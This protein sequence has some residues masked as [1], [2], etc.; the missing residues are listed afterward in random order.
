MSKC[1]IMTRGRT[2]LLALCVLALVTLVTGCGEDGSSDKT[3]PGGSA[4]DTAAGVPWDTEELVLKPPVRDETP[5]TGPS[6]LPWEKEGDVADTIKDS[7]K[8]RKNWYEYEIR[9]RT[10]ADT[11][12]FADFRYAVFLEDELLID[13]LTPDK[14]A[15][16][17]PGI[18]QALESK[19]QEFLQEE[20][21]R[22]EDLARAQREKPVIFKSAE[23]S[24]VTNDQARAI[25][26]LF[27]LFGVDDIVL[28]MREREIEGIKRVYYDVLLDDERVAEN[29][30]AE[31]FE[32]NGLW[33][34]RLAEKLDR[35]PPTAAPG[36]AYL[37]AFSNH[38]YYHKLAIEKRGDE[39][40]L[41]EEDRNLKL[42][43]P[44]K[45]IEQVPVRLQGF[46]KRYLKKIEWEEAEIRYAKARSFYVQIEWS[47][48][49]RISVPRYN[50]YVDDKLVLKNVSR[51]ELLDQPPTLKKNIE[52]QLKVLESPSPPGVE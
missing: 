32:P 49:G 21:K 29:V 2:S 46:L 36:A 35:K 22:Q 11:T 31:K 52:E 30:P 10:D 43:L 26:E 8:F 28:E 38:V 34:M 51:E 23:I 27:L 41:T 3:H 50:V 12:A 20:R 4:S 44:V 14:F 1:N 42:T 40:I 15:E 24:T 19:F 9:V 47:R 18:R 37:A 33:A 16:Q 45:S 13:N 17:E 5:D 48:A 25:L 7:T 6:A 39:L